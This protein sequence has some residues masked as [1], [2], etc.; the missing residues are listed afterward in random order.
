MINMIYAALS[1]HAQTEKTTFSC[2]DDCLL[3]KHTWCWTYSARDFEIPLCHTSPLRSFFF[4]LSSFLCKIVS[5]L[6]IILLVVYNKGIQH[7]CKHLLTV[8]LLNRKYK[9]LFYFYEFS[10]GK[11]KMKIVYLK[12]V[13]AR[14]LL[15]RWADVA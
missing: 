9:L 12:V 2:K 10:M 13:L 1:I 3:T 11:Y 4:A 5:V 15:T 8:P 7:E 6:L 14:Y